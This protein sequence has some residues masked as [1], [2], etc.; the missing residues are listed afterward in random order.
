MKSFFTEFALT[1]DQNSDCAPLNT[2]DIIS[3][4]NSNSF[5]DLNGDCIPD[6]IWRDIQEDL[7][8]K[9]AHI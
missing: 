2:D 9:Y 8:D 3:L 5:V 1:P 6:L 4:P 7:K